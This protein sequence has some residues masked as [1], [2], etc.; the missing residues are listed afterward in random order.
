[1]PD[2]DPDR[3]SLPRD[4]LH[5]LLHACGEGL[6]PSLA[7]ALERMIDHLE[8]GRARREPAR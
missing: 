8:R 5:D 7:G 1:M 3:R 2:R 4:D 6:S